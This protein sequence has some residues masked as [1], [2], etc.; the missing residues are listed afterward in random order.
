MQGYEAIVLYTKKGVLASHCNAN[1]LITPAHMP[2]CCQ[3][4]CVSQAGCGW[5][6]HLVHSSLLQC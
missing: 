1:P 3:G 4:D 5:L 6:A 2:G